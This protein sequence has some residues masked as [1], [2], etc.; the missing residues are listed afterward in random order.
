MSFTV[1][2]IERL[3]SLWYFRGLVHISP[4]RRHTAVVVGGDEEPREV[5]TGHVLRPELPLDRRD[6][7]EPQIRRRVADASHAR[8]RH[9]VSGGGWR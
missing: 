8:G 4:L 2:F 5:G 9:L 1:D 7:A 6:A 3:L